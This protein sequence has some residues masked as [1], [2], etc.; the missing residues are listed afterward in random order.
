MFLH[1]QPQEFCE[2]HR[3]S[4]GEVEK[5]LRLSAPYTHDWAN[6]RFNWMILDV[7]MDAKE[8][9]R[10]GHAPMLDKSEERDKMDF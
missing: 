2:H 9:F 1:P 10:M 3:I 8:I 4:V 5:I 6:R 7:D